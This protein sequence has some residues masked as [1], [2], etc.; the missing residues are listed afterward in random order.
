M[1]RHVSVVVN[2]K[3]CL[4]FQVDK[5]RFED[6][7]SFMSY[8]GALYV[9]ADPGSCEALVNLNENI[10]DYVHLYLERLNIY[11]PRPHFLLSAIKPLIPTYNSDQRNLGDD[12]DQ[13]KNAKLAK[14]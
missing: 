14:M 5:T 7:P 9:I 6:T 2:E 10:S 11:V 1:T 13:S 3:G 12:C 8:G 4:V